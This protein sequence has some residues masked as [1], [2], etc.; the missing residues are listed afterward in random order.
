MNVLRSRGFDPEK[1]ATVT[2]RIQEAEGGTVLDR[3]ELLQLLRKLRRRYGNTGG[4]EYEAELQSAESTM[5]IS[6]KSSS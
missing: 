4:V 1:P 3:R 6:S 5:S 2:I